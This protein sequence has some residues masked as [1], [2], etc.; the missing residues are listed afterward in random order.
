VVDILGRLDVTLNWKPE[1]DL[2][3]VRIKDGASPHALT[4]ERD[5]S[6]VRVIPAGGSWQ[7]KEVKTILKDV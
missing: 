4:S 2:K 6:R 7:A 3:L 1:V 5:N